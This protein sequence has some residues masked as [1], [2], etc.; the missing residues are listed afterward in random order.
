MYQKE[1]AVP[2]TCGLGVQRPTVVTVV[3][4]KPG[5]AAINADVFA[6]DD[7]Y[8]VLEHS[9]PPQG[10]TAILITPSSLFSKIR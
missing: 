6:G 4:H 8:F 9:Y 1:E 10:I 5:L 2:D 7:D 3:D